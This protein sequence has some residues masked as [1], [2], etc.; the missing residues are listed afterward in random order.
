MPSGRTRYGRIALVERNADEEEE[1]SEEE[2][3]DAM[4]PSSDEANDDTRPQPTNERAVQQTA[5]QGKIHVSL[6]KSSELLCHVSF[7]RPVASL[8]LR[9][10]GTVGAAR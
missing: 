9:T 2:D 1:S 5:K 8:V 4:D 10:Y 6:G 7:S 3:E